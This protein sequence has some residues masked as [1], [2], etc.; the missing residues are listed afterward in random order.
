MLHV[1]EPGQTNL[2]NDSA[3]AYLRSA[4]HQPVQWHPWGEAAFA[5]ATAGKGGQR[6]VTAAD[7]IYVGIKRWLT[8]C[9]CA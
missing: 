9:A 6:N 1:S 3:S 7:F 5:K 8:T 4:R 2:L